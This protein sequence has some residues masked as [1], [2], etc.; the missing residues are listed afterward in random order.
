M[1]LSSRQTC[2]N[3]GSQMKQIT[4]SLYHGF[5]TASH[6]S[7]LL[8]FANAYSVEDFFTYLFS[9]LNV[10]LSC[11]FPFLL[12]RTKSQQKEARQEKAEKQ[13]GKIFNPILPRAGVDYLPCSLALI[14][15]KRDP[16]DSPNNLILPIGFKVLEHSYTY[17]TKQQTN[18]SLI[19]KAAPLSVFKVF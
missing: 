5:A 14:V 15:L 16:L 19:A 12:K 11:R 4:K 6:I 7:I 1:P 13:R 18:R 2:L 17:Y 3:K 9:F 10:T 8:C